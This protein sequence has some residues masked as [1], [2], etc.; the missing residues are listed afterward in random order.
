MRKRSLLS[1]CPTYY[2]RAKEN[3]VSVKGYLLVNIGLLVFMLFKL[4]Y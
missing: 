4:N 1:R 3:D 2:G